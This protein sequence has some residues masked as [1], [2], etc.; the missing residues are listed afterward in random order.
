MPQA[1]L[2]LDRLCLHPP[3]S[4]KR[5]LAPSI[6]QCFLGWTLPCT[7]SKGRWVGAF[8]E[9]WTITAHRHF[10]HKE[11]VWLRTPQLCLCC[12]SSK[13]R[14]GPGRGSQG[15][16]EQPT[17]MV[18]VALKGMKML[19]SCIL[20]MVPKGCVNQNQ[21]KKI[22]MVTLSPWSVLVQQ[23]IWNSSRKGR[24]QLYVQTWGQEAIQ[25]LGLTLLQPRSQTK[26]VGSKGM[27]QWEGGTETRLLYLMF[28]CHLPSTDQNRFHTTVSDS[29]YSI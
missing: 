26:W 23:G 12:S 25:H 28:C 5:S 2:G 13:S 20:S 24:P 16:K 19:W 4:A 27:A 22:R 10:G 11:Y 15:S 7:S 9:W 18:N 8:S 6:I 3:Q 14:S 1:L 17:E 21:G 29:L